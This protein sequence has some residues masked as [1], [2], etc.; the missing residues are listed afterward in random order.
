MALLDVWIG[1]YCYVLIQAKWLVSRPFPG[2]RYVFFDTFEVNFL[3]C[4]QDVESTL[5][6]NVC[7]FVWTPSSPYELAGSSFWNDVA[8]DPYSVAD[9]MRF[10]FHMTVKFLLLSKLRLCVFLRTNS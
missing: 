5:L 2:S 8:K 7:C 6:K 9:A 1:N 3:P 10:C 4:V